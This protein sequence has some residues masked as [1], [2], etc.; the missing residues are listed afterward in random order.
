MLGH[1][2]LIF[3][4]ALVLSL[5]VAAVETADNP[6]Q[7]KDKSSSQMEDKSSSE[8]GEPE[9]HHHHKHPG[10]SG[11]EEETSAQAASEAPAEE[12]SAADEGSP[13][14]HHHHKHDEKAAETKVTPPPKEEKAHLHHEFEHE[15]HMMDMDAD[16]MVMN[17]NTDNLPRD[18]PQIAGDVEITVRAGTKYAE[19]FPGTVFGF[20]QHEWNVEPCTRITVTF[21]NEDNVRHQWMVHMLPKYIYPQG[22]FHL[23]V[24]GPGRRTGTFIVPSVE[25][26]YFVHCDIAQHTEK[27]MKAQ[28]KV[29][30]GDQDFPSIPG[31]TAQNYPDSYETETSWSTIGSSLGAGLA[32][33]A[34][35]VVGLGRFKRKTGVKEAEQRQVSKPEAETKSSKRWP[36]SRK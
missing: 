3:V 24:A 15:H 25:K 12:D 11:T 26:T 30:K 20:D 17:E 2:L 19:E 5:N 29:G 9:H 7:D 8:A 18:C 14:H 4:A 21:I 23:E 28:L 16:G 31:I 35:A 27:G 32:G 1:Q 36:W 34:L 13:A 6:E 22:M 10:D 33:V